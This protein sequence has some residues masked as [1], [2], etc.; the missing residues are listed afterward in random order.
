MSRIFKLAARQAGYGTPQPMRD[1]LYIKVS[2]KEPFE[3]LYWNAGATSIINLHD[4]S[5]TLIPEV[6][7]TGITPGTARAPGVA[8]RR[9]RYRLRR[10]AQ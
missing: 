1:Y 5:Y 10:T 3:A 7:Y 4:S 9:A 8:R 6:S 2:Q